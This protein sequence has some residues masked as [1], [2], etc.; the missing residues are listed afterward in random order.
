[1][2][3]VPTGLSDTE[4]TTGIGHHGHHHGQSTTATGLGSTGTAYDNQRGDR[5]LG[6]DAVAGTT[7][8]DGAYEAGHGHPSSSSTSGAQNI[9]GPVHNSSLLNKIDPR[10]KQ[11]DTSNVYGDSGLDSTGSRGLTGTNKDYHYGRDAT[12][13]GAVGAAGYEAEKHHHK[14]NVT[15]TSGLSGTNVGP[16]YGQQSGSTHHG[17]RDAT[18]ATGGTAVAYETEKHLHHRDQPTGAT[19]GLTGNVHDQQPRSVHLCRDAALATGGTTAAYE[20]EKHHHSRDQPAGT[21]TSS[22]YPSTYDQHG[23]TGTHGKRDAAL[24]AGAGAGAAAVAG[25]EFSKKDAEREQKQLAKEESKHE[26]ALEKDHKQQEKELEKEEKHHDKLLAK[27]EKKHE[28]A[29]EK[30]EK[31]HEK[32]VEKDAKHDGKKGGIFGFVS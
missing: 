15:G 11:Q 9:T 3:P 4:T 29:L 25:S 12:V 16:T 14:D 18:L 22:T 21:G 28:K 23:T 10:V 32:E 27:E 26:K 31:K 7:S 24:G 20:A 2:S 19:S 1:M 17:G 5:H 8:V 13:A 30:Q 6:R